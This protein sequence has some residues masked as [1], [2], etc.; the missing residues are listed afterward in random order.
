[1]AWLTENWRDILVAFGVTIEMT[2]IAGVIALVVGF[3]LAA[4]R[5]S[6]V[7]VGRALGA[8]YVRLVRNTPLLLI[9]LLFAFG[10][11]ELDLRPSIDLGSWFGA[12]RHQDLLS[13]DVFFL[14]ATI[15]L[16]MY[17]AA[18]VCEA[19]RSGIGSISLGQAEAARSVGMTFGQTLRLVI[20]PQAFRAVVPPLAS[21]LI[22]MTKNTS[23]A[24][25]VGVTDATF[26]MH[27]LT[28]HYS[29][30]TLTIF[31]GFAIGYMVLV[32][33]IATTSSTLERRLAV[34]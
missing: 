30:Q 8:V 6:P 21:T 16:G 27:S 4:L 1:M 19:V 23:V 5:V 29:S 7:P 20:L 25:G 17:T 34:A 22:A 3:L 11:P 15:G 18:F 14:F 13:F 31:V 24:A 26:R 32:A 10:L 12:G 2:V 9:M 33:I 28:N